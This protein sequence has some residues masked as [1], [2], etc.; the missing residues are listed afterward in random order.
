[1]N[2]VDESRSISNFSGD[3]KLTMKYNPGETCPFMATDDLLNLNQHYRLYFSYPITGTEEPAEE[4][5][6]SVYPNPSNGIIWV[7]SPTNSKLVLQ[8]IL[9]RIVW[10]GI[11]T[12]K[13]QLALPNGT[14]GQFL[15][16]VTSENRTTFRMV[17]IQ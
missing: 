9:G 13:D 11:S 7:E 6:L 5:P 12:G 1:M 2:R 3:T 10:Q 17:L 14:K 15:L 4:I 8:D 16:H